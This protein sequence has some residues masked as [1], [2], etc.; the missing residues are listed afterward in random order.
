MIMK[1]LLFCSIPQIY[2]INVFYI[3]VF[4][5]DILFCDSDPVILK[6]VTAHCTA[7]W[8]TVNHPQNHESEFRSQSIRTKKI[9]EDKTVVRRF[10]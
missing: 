10:L 5:S 7:H 1:K 9:L 3:S 2:R 4:Y 8:F 6:P